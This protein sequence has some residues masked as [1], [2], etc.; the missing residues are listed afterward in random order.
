[1][2]DGGRQGLKEAQSFPNDYDGIVAG[3]PANYWTHLVASGVWIAQATLRDQ[4]SYI[5]REKYSLRILIAALKSGLCI[6]FHRRTT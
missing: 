4:S 3:A 2:L 5:P 1:M 6:D